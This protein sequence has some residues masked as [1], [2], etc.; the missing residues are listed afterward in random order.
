MHIFIYVHVYTYTY[1]YI[2]TYI[3]IDRYI[4]RKRG[5]TDLG[6]LAHTA[7]S[8]AVRLSSLYLV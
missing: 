5:E 2:H 3:Y 8:K 1:I 6:V 7:R 4:G